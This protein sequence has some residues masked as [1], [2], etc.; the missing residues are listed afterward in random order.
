M[1]VC[2]ECAILA[3]GA[4]H[5]PADALVRNAVHPATL[6]GQ[7]GELELRHAPRRH[8]LCAGVEGLKPPRRGRPVVLGE[9]GSLR[10]HALPD[11]LLEIWVKQPVVPAQ[12]NCNLLVQIFQEGAVLPP[13][14]GEI[15]LQD[16]AALLEPK[17]LVPWTVGHRQQHIHQHVVLVVVGVIQA[18]LDVSPPTVGVVVR[19]GA[20]DVQ[21]VLSKIHAPKTI[22]CGVAVE[23]VS[24]PRERVFCNNAFSLILSGRKGLQL[25]DLLFGELLGADVTYG[26]RILVAGSEMQQT[27]ADGV[28]EGLLQAHCK[29]VGLGARPLPRQQASV[30]ALPRNQRIFVGRLPAPR[31]RQVVV[32]FRDRVLV[33]VLDGRGVQTASSLRCV[34]KFSSVIFLHLCARVRARER[35]MRARASAACARVSSIA[36]A[37][38]TC[39]GVC[40]RTCESDQS[41]QLVQKTLGF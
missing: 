28:D 26:L 16:L 24:W 1:V 34:Q 25:S 32:K 35:R 38:N 27:L 15:L 12:I 36:C 22:R 19:T 17:R 21:L 9:Q 4:F 14:D 31:Q 5:C 6:H 3:G 37:R 13:G 8:Q 2:S 41:K 33:C 30:C 18:A 40:D 10:L 29:L 23:H 11:V 20:I 39:R 7:I